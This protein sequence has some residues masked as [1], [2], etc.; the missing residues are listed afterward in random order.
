LAQKKPQ[1]PGKETSLGAS[2]SDQPA[3]QHE[4]AQTRQTAH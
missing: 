3:D 4:H 2:A 1:K